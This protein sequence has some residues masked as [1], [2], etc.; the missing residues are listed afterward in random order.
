[1][2]QVTP[3]AGEVT[4]KTGTVEVVVEVAVEPVVVDGDVDCE[5]GGDAAVVAG[6]V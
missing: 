5:V 1:M 2:G 4:E 3:L 6:E